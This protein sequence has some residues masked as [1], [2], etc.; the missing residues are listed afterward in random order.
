MHATDPDRLEQLLGTAQ[1]KGCI[2]I[3]ASL[4]EFID[5][6]GALDE[7]YQEKTDEGRRFWVLRGDRTPTRGQD[8]T[9]SSSIRCLANGPTGRLHLRRVEAD[10]LSPV[11]APAHH[12]KAANRHALGTPEHLQHLG[13]DSPGTD[14]GEPSA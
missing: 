8:A 14:L 10:R 12:R 1:S 4:N 2:R 9:W 13:F 3:P 6:H 7:D 11:V 5:R